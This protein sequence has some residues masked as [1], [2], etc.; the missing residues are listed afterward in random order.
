MSIYIDT[1]GYNSLVLKI[2]RIFSI[3]LITILIFLIGLRSLDIGADTISYYYHWNKGMRFSDVKS[4]LCFTLMYSIKAIGLSY[5]YFL[6]IV[7]TLFFATVYRAYQKI[8]NL[9]NLN[10]LLL[11]FS[12]F[13]LFFC[14]SL[15][16]NVIRQGVSLA[17]LLLCYSYYIQPCSK[18]KVLVYFILS[19]GFHLTTL[20]PICLYLII[21]ICKRINLIYYYFI[22]ILGVILAYI[23]YGINNVPLYIPEIF[24][25]DKRMSYLSSDVSHYEVGF[26]FQFTIFNSIFLIIFILLRRINKDRKYELLL[27]YYILASFVFFMTFQIPFS[28]RWGLFSWFFIPL[29]LSPVFSIYQRKYKLSVIT[30]LFLIFIFV[31]FNVLYK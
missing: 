22:Y 15:S 26:K 17:F 29:L 3:L 18:K 27:K 5:Q 1:K 20:I 28:D 12:L 30:V 9:N 31:F 13:S 23:G 21:Y 10:L 11:L 24:A 14:L 19:I 2:S 6:L 7:S 8:S 4:D 16:T 25:N